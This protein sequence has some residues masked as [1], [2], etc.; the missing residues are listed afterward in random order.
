MKRSEDRAAVAEER[1]RIVMD[2]MRTAAEHGDKAP[3]NTVLATAL[4]VGPATASNVVE[5]CETMNLIRVDRGRSDRVVTI[6]ATGARTAGKVTGKPA[7]PTVWTS[8]LDAALMDAVA[9]GIGFPE[10]A[11]DLR[12]S[13]GAV[14]RRFE[15]LRARFG[16]QAA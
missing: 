4:G 12:L 2:M 8:D 15:L 1:V 9:E 16:G 13:L 6:V 3:A 10:I 5:L 7:K 11:R 14:K